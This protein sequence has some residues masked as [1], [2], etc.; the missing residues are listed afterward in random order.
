VLSGDANLAGTDESCTVVTPHGYQ[1]QIAAELP[2]G[3]HALD[4]MAST[5]TVRLCSEVRCR[6]GNLSR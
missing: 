4:G 6:G 1:Q 5:V 2:C 3:H